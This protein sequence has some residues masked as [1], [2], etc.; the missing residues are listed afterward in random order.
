MTRAL[1]EKSA[2]R[3]ALRCEGHAETSGACNYI[4][5]VMYTLAS[6]AETIAQ[7]GDAELLT[8]EIDAQAPRFAVECRG[9][10]RMEAVFDAAVLALRRLEMTDGREIQ[11]ECAEFS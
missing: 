2:G 4:V 5:G 1:A 3:Y 10:T 8:L 6:Y 9:D 11:V 7:E